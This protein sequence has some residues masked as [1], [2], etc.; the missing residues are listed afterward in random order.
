MEVEKLKVT[1]WAPDKE[2]TAGFYTKVF[3]AQVERQ[4]SAVTE[5][6][7]AGG[8]IAIHGG[9]EGK[10]TWTG[11]TLQVADVVRGAEEVQEAGGSLTSPIDDSEGE[12][13]HLAMCMDPA[14]NRFMLSR[15]RS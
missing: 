10:S 3:N 4:N 7:I 9:G 5:V 13:P 8:H 6:S 12:G 14:G 1:I 11:L 2:A 15:R